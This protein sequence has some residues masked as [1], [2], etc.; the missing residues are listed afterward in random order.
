M[1]IDSQVH[2]YEANTPQRPWHSIPNWPDHVTGDEMVAAMDAVGVDGAIFISAFS[3]YRYDAGYAVEVQRAH[4]DRFAIVKPVDPDDAAVDDVVAE[5]KAT[6]GAVG[7]RIMLWP[8]A[9]RDPN[10]PGLDR[11]ARAAVRHDFPLNVLCWGNLDAGIALI[12]RHPDT[13]FI[14]DHLG[15]MQPRTKPTPAA[16]LEQPWGELP[17]VLELAGR[18]NVVIKVSGA[19]TLSQQPYPFADIWDPLARVFD[20]FGFERC[21][22]GT[23]WTRAFAVVNYEEATKPFLETDRLSAGERAMLMGGACAKAYG[24]SPKRS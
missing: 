22:W 14:L 5:W 20:A 11:I 18:P 19:C 13:R 23:D 4:P 16:P 24:W 8:E 1:I 7:I 10:D 21:L 12:D 15:L 6:P 2:A 9:K 17:K 3:L